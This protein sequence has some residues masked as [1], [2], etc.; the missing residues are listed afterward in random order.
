MPDLPTKKQPFVPGGSSEAT[1]TKSGV[2]SVQRGAKEGFRGLL[3][4][5]WVTWGE[6]ERSRE[7][8]EER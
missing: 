1:S 7:R 4:G 2:L 8:S 6:E 5:F 3:R